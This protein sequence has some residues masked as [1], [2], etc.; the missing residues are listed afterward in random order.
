MKCVSAIALIACLLLSGCGEMP[1]ESDALDAEAE[2]RAAAAR[3]AEAAKWKP[4]EVESGP[5][6]RTDF[7]DVDD[8][9]AVLSEAAAKENTDQIWAVIKWLVPQGEPVKVR[10]VGIMNDAS[11]DVADRLAACMVLG[12]M[13]NAAHD[14]I[15]QAAVSSDLFNVRMRATETL[16][17]LT[18]ATPET[19]N[20]LIKKLDEEKDDRVLR[21]VVRALGEI[22]EPAQ[23]AAGKLNAMRDDVS[24]RD[25]TLRNEAHR[26]LKKV[27]PRRDFTGLPIDKQSP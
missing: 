9:W 21:H 20:A 18:P 8:A 23:A 2:A 6:P 13:G 12:E 7:T 22:G 3:A 14:E 10:M 26:A 5:P 1:S 24:A 27:D 4:P 16:G 15:L 11:A 17:K 25:D 19:I